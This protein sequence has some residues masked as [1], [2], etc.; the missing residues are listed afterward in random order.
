M[1]DGK[2]QAALEFMI[3]VL[4]LVTVMIFF[5]IYSGDKSAEGRAMYSKLKA[6]EICWKVSNIINT[7]MYSKG[8]YSEFSLP[9]QIDGEGYNISVTDG[10]VSVDY[11]GKSCIYGITTTNISFRSQPA[12]FS[13]CGGDYYI[14]NTDNAVF[15]YNRSPVGC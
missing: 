2:A 9:L 15:V 10:S 4:I 6:D 8:Y 1:G 11:R 5:T 7:A 14:N 13:L 3:C 12:P